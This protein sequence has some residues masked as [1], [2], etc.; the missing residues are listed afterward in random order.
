MEQQRELIIGPP[1]TGKTTAC[2][3]IVNDALQ[4]GTPPDRIGFV[5]FT[6]KAAEEAKQRACERFKLAPKAFPYFRTLHSIAF[7][8][9]GLSRNEVMQDKD[10]K[11][12]GDAL[13]YR[14]RNIHTNPAVD[15]FGAHDELG[16]KC[17]HIEQLARV[18]C[19]PL[20]EQWQ[21][22]ALQDCPWLAVRQ[23]GATLEQYKRERGLFDFADMIDEC[24][25]ELPIELLIVDEAQDLTPQQFSFVARIAAQVPQVYFAGDDMQAIYNW[26]GAD[27]KQFMGIAASRRVLPH[28][29]RLPH[30]VHAVAKQV[31][32]RVQRDYVRE[33]TARDEA[34]VVERVAELEALNISSGQW[35]L[36]ARNTYLLE[37][38]RAWVRYCGHPYIMHGK[39]SLD[40]DP[41]QAVLAYEHVRQ[42]KVITR[43]EA[44]L[45]ARFASTFEVPVDGD[46]FTRAMLPVDVNK[47]WMEAFDMLSP[48]E[49][50][51]IR[52]IKK[53]GESLMAAPRIT[54]STVHGA[55]GGEAD[56][57]VVM[58]D[59]SS[60]SW[61]GM[62]QDAA[63]EHRVQY[64]AYTRAKQKLFLLNPQ[65]TRYYQL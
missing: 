39:S 56:N 13:G 29:Y 51:Y 27:V 18:G 6:K 35:L 4:R 23:F 22:L 50:E 15:G 7:K 36:L 8:E 14:F 40:S 52:A 48:Y 44:R 65:T 42:G 24:H 10:Y 3:N 25:T 12:I 38:Y 62:L 63:G 43:K 5:S 16:D 58:L 47:N 59:M 49:R 53:N 41:V 64:T 34:G 54:I 57:T 33:W 32:G 28:S 21:L 9:L 30:A 46:Q 45:V 61:D 2:L 19:R 26:A 11:R 20:H 60:R 37:K 17:F 1:G 31:E 55:K